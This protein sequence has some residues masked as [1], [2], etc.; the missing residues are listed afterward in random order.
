MK[1]MSKLKKAISWLCLVILLLCMTACNSKTEDKASQEAQTVDNKE[2]EAA[3][4]RYVEHELQLPDGFEQESILYATQGKDG[5]EAFAYNAQ[6]VLYHLSYLNG[7][8]EQRE[9][10]WYQQ[11]QV[12]NESLSSVILG[13]DGNYYV[14]SMLCNDKTGISTLVYCVSGETLIPVDLDFFDG[15]SES[16]PIILKLGVLKDGTFLYTDGSDFYIRSTENKEL[17]YGEG[18]NDFF[19][20]GDE[21]LLKNQSGQCI[22]RMDTTG[23]RIQSYPVEF[24]IEDCIVGSYEDDIYIFS[25]KGGLY[26]CNRQGTLWQNLIDT[27]IL[28]MPN[29]DPVALYAKQNGAY[30]DYQLV[31]TD[32]QRGFHLLSY[33]YDETMLATP[34]E[35]FTIYSLKENPTIRQAISAYKTAHPEIGI[36]YITSEESTSLSDT[37]RA[38]NT[39]L[40]AGNGADLLLLD[41]LPEQTYREKGILADITDLVEEHLNAGKLLKNVVEPF[42][43]QEHYYSVP[44]KV[45]VPMVYGDQSVIE[46]M[47]SLDSL[48]AY[49]KSHS[50]EDVFDLDKNAI[51]ETF[52]KL[53][54]NE[55][56]D[57]ATKQVKAHALE[58]YAW[59]VQELIHRAEKCNTEAETDGE[60]AEINDLGY[61]FGIYMGEKGDSSTRIAQ[62][63][64]ENLI[65]VPYYAQT[66][67]GMQCEN[68]HQILIPSS[69]VGINA[70]SSHKEVVKDFVRTL[71]GDEVQSV[72]N[73]DGFSLNPEVIE[74]NFVYDRFKD[75][76]VVLSMGDSMAFFEPVT[77]EQLGAFKMILTTSEKTYSCDAVVFQMIVS[78]V[79]KYLEGR[80]EIGQF[81]QE[82]EN[83]ITTYLAE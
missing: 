55:I 2:K 42:C 25:S 21:I 5:I 7:S 16:Y 9:C 38:L 82:M 10:P 13:D 11:L 30:L 41:G 70:S 44:V 14:V 24:G 51:P 23:K 17:Y 19:I 64:E 73:Q 69:V 72:A 15:N 40:L 35:E 29:V 74:K 68:Y 61:G 67:E 46:S 12:R 39:E 45:M 48:C 33:E 22:D 59:L 75:M 52:L 27:S 47:D 60:T 3:R 36:Q 78:G 65:A 34:S 56:V 62:L 18:C 8:W 6:G 26:C 37:V 79:S 4:G 20:H 57:A 71:L 43:V 80:L 76:G 32:Q 54:Y 81:A 66:K 83:Q 50:R 63:K 53:Y 31:T 49:L 1:K 58:Q 77:E 28:T